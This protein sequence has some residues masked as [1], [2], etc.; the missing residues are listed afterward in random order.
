MTKG[1]QKEYSILDADPHTISGLL[2]AFSL[3]LEMAWE[4]LNI[5]VNLRHRWRAFESPDGTVTRQVDAEL[6]AVPLTTA[7]LLG[8]M[9]LPAGKG[10]EVLTDHNDTES[11]QI[12]T[13]DGELYALPPSAVHPSAQVHGGFAGVRISSGRGPR[14]RP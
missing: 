3:P 6:G 4:M 12:V 2:A 11:L 10:L 7:P 14:S 8:H 9:F 5:P 1:G 13:V